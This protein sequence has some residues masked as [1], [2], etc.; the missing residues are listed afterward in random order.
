MSDYKDGFK[1]GTNYNHRM[2]HANYDPRAEIAA[3]IALGAACARGE[4]EEATAEPKRVTYAGG[5]RLAV[6]TRYCCRC[7][8][9][10]AEGTG[11]VP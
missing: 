11:P 4:H 9:I 1:R 10:L 5:R 2:A 6:G 8:T 3:G 7:G